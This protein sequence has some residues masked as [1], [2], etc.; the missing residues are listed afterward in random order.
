M[1]VALRVAA[2]VAMNHQRD[3]VNVDSNIIALLVSGG[4]YVL[5]N[6]K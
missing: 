4:N 3:A 2:N 1:R 5:S 6:N